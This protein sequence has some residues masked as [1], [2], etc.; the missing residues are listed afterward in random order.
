MDTFGCIFG[1]FQYQSYMI[2]IQFVLWYGIQF[3]LCIYSKQDEEDYPNSTWKKA[4]LQDWLV[5]NNIPFPP[6]ALRPELYK[7]ARKHAV[8]NPRYRVDKMI[9]DAGHFV[10]RLPP[11]H[12]DL[13]PIERI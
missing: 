12:C 8:N 5:K 7:I 6:K 13:N 1:E 2:G 9:H 4:K 10:L 3:V 11:Y